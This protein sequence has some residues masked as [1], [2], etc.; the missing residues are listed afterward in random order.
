MK[1]HNATNEKD[2]ET[3]VFSVDPAVRISNSK[4]EF[5][6]GFSQTGKAL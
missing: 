1:V 2:P 3:G 6:G 5:P 4:L